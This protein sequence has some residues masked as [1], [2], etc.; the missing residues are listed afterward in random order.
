[1]ERESGSKAVAQG[2]IELFGVLSET[3]IGMG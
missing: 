3:R 2:R 1:M